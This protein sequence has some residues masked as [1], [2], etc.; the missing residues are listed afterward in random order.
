MMMVMYIVK[1][2]TKKCVQ[3]IYCDARRALWIRNM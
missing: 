3:D 2:T 1:E